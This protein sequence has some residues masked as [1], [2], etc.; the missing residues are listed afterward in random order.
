MSHPFGGPL[1]LEYGPGQRPATQAPSSDASAM[2]RM[3]NVSEMMGTAQGAQVYRMP[4]FPTAPFY[5]T[6]P[7][8]GYQP[9]FYS[10]GIL[11]APVGTEQLVTVLFDL[12]CRIIAFNGAAFNTGVGNALPVGVG[13][14]DCFLF[15]AE[16]TTGDRL[17]ISSRMAS[18]VLGTAERPGEMGATGYTVDQGAALTLGITPLLPNLRIDVSVHCL[19]MRGPRNFVGR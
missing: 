5:S 13:P 8:V 18:T 10:Q 3:P 4:F 2:I 7:D 6:R 1:A 11:N 9:R 14:R 19:E 16:Y 15:R 12:P 17:M